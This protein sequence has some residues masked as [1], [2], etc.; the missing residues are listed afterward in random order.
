MTHE[1]G[2]EEP[3]S[4]IDTIVAVAT[5]P[6]VGAIAVLRLSGPRAFDLTRALVGRAAVD[7]GATGSSR[8]SEDPGSTGRRPGPGSDPLDL[9]RARV[10]QVVRLRR[11]EDG[12]A[13]DQAVV[14]CFPG[15]DSYT[16]EDL[17]E[18]STHGGRIAP[19]LV[20]DALVEL[21]ARL[22]RAGEFTQRAWLNGKVDLLQAEA[23][24]DLVEGR[25][26][27]LHRVALH[28]LDR[29]LSERVAELRDALIGL[30]ATLAHH[31]DFPEEDD[32][33]VPVGE[34]AARA[35]D[36]AERFR[37]LGATA[38]VGR[39]LRSGA[40]AVLAGRPNA[41][42]SSLLNALAGEE[43]AIV[44]ERPGTTRDRIEVD[45]ELDGLPFRLVDTAGLRDTPDEVERMGVEVARRALESADVVLFCIPAGVAFT[46]PELAFLRDHVSAPVILVRTQV[47]RSDVSRSSA[48]PT[49]EA[50][51]QP[52]LD[53]AGRVPVSALTGEGLDRLRDVLVESVFSGRVAPGR[54]GPLLTRERQVKGVRIAADEIAAFGGALR[55]GIPPEVAAA[56]LKSAATATE[57]LLGSV[58]TEDVLDRVFSDFCVGK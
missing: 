33:P 19:R 10:A 36:L 9:A 30:E 58:G 54:D 6:G 32:A 5:P 44:T 27:A 20:M 12:E 40:L 13:L 45:V 25:S 50:E 3:D 23:V 26:Q 4:M 22:A 37:R 31:V 7:G 16:G 49:R 18:I 55:R 8:R 51:V 43:R 14:T 48:D 56:H 1:D 21:G 15:P 2:L 11:P 34:I 28:Q 35:D 39:L 24:A 46:V 52:D 57:E 29:G 41:G 53:L 17:V 47:D 38:P 42:K